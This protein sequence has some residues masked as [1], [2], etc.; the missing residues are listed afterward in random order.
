MSH[1][2]IKDV[3]FPFYND[4]VKVKIVVFRGKA[5]YKIFVYTWNRIL[6]T[7]IL[8]LTNYWNIC[9]QRNLFPQT[10]SWD[11]NYTS[12]QSYRKILEHFPLPSLS[13][14]S[15]IHSG[16]IDAVKC[17]QTLSNEDKISN[18]VCLMFAKCTYKNVKNILLAIWWAVTVSVN[19]RKDWFALW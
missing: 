4:F 1:I 7:F 18:D 12:I 16:K 10:K 5:C 6:K 13:L 2:F 8:Y 9:S 15:K 17:A 3:L 14:L 19:Y 11:M